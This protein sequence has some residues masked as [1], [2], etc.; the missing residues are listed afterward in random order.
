MALSTTDGK[1]KA[2]HWPIPSARSVR[3]PVTIRGHDIDAT[4]SCA[5]YLAWQVVVND[6][7][8][9]LEALDI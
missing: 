8:S 7:N 3:L 2:T 4:C 6:G 5:L 1:T 9:I